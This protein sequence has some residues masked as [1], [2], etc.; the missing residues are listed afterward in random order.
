M[1]QLILEQGLVVHLD[2]PKAGLTD[3]GGD[4]E[5]ETATDNVR[6][7]IAD[8]KVVTPCSL[9]HEHFLPRG[10]V[11]R[12]THWIVCVAAYVGD[13]SK[14]RLNVANT[15]AKISNMQHY[16]NQCIYG[17]VAFL[18]FFCIYA[19]IQGELQEDPE[20][21]KVKIRSAFYTLPTTAQQEADM[22][23]AIEDNW[24]FNKNFGVHFL[25]FWIILYQVVPIS[26]YVCFEI[27]KLVL[28]FQINMDKQMFDKRTQLGAFARTADLVE[29]LG[30][31]DFIFSDKTGTL[32]ENEMVFARACIQGDD[33]GD[34]RPDLTNGNAANLAPGIAETQRILA[35]AGDPRQAEIRWFFLCLGTCHAAQVELSPEGVPHYSGSSPD[36]V[37]FLEAAH[38]CGISF[39]ARRRLPGSSGWELQIMGPPG[40]GP[41]ILTVLC[42]I[43][44][45]SERKRMSIICEHK[46]EFFCIT[47]GADNVISALC[48]EP[49]PETVADQLMKYSKQGLRTLAIASKIVDKAFLQEWQQKLAIAGS[50]PEE[51]EERL[52]EVAAEMEH[53]LCLSGVSAI[54]DKLQEGVPEAIVTVKAAGIRFWVLTGDKTETAVEIARSCRLLTEDMVLAYM[55]NCTS[56]ENALQMLKDAKSKLGG[57]EDGGLIIDGTFTKFCLAS[58]EA[59]RELYLLAISTSSCV[60]C[61]LSPQQKRKLV[62]LV[63]QENKLG[64]TLAIGDGANDVSMIQG[65]HIGIGVRGKEGNQAV[66]ASDIAVSQ[67]RFIVPLLL[68]HGRR[69]Y[70]RVA[71]FLCYYIYKHIVLATAD[72]IWAHQF[73]FRGAIAYPEWLSS[74]YSVAFTSLPVMVIVG[75]D[76]DVPDAV[77]VNDPGLY[78]EGLQRTRFNFK[79]FTLWMIS[80]VWHGCLAWAVPSIILGSTEFLIEKVGSDGLPSLDGDYKVKMVPDFWLASC[81]AFTLV[82]FLVDLRL[83]MV[84]MDK[85]SLPTL[86]MLFLSVLAYIVVLFVFGHAWTS[87]QPQIENIPLKMFENQTALL[88]IFLTPLATLI[89]LVLYQGSKMLY[90]G[91]LDKARRKNYANGKDNTQAKLKDE[92]GKPQAAW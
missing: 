45:S 67:F 44:F 58:P 9:N 47:K 33:L 55:V 41:H 72:V 25:V 49:F 46:G 73:R 88:C 4:V 79:V 18:V 56:E 65:A 70:R 5:M 8:M 66:Q 90:P 20:E 27:V 17:L 85:F 29:E 39:Q 40:E 13:E 38:S 31:V 87:M 53:S 57:T 75:F 42:E 26:L 37:A 28:G 74:C 59:R 76:H 77:A 24:D 83:W 15:D 84:S 71:T 14:T 11:L 12:N 82:V 62:E 36:E 32:T 35:T 30:Q 34:F 3:L 23:K 91:P 6:Q 22:S 16:L 19:G 54:E 21:I 64:I 52:A 61:R 60:C 10:C 43:P 92:V 68:C 86:L 51:R 63:K 48:D 80:G 89:D 7:T 69:A 1:A 81:V 78:I 2:E 50:A